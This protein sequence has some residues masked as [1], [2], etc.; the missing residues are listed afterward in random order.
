MA[1]HRAGLHKNISSIFDG[2][3]VSKDKDAGQVSSAA[4]EEPA[5]YGPP[6]HLTGTTTKSQ[7]PEAGP[8]KAEPTEERKAAP[9]KKVT[10]KP[11]AV[12]PDRP[13][14]LEQTIQRIK[15]KLFAP[16]PGVNSARQ[17]MMVVLMP[18]MFIGMVVAFYKVLGV[19]PKGT[20]QAQAFKP[21]KAVAAAASTIDWQIP[22][23]YPTTL[24]DPMQIGSVSTTTEGEIGKIIVK[25]IVY[26]EDDPSAIIGT[27][28][29][30]EGEKVSGATIIKINKDSVEFEMNGKRWTEKVR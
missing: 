3:P 23:L 10:E 7:R 12:K 14:A 18:V 15:D 27:E 5:N 4:L 22:P 26:S 20:T 19:G 9:E 21:S 13:G 24:R 6:S 16:K 29:M 11:K 17:K 25:G 8:P 28:I 1:K 2:V 30:H